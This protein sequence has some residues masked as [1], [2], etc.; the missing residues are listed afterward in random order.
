MM[1]QNQT[2]IVTGAGRGI[3]KAIATALAGEGA[4]IVVADINAEWSEKTAEGLR[5]V[6]RDTLAVSLDVTKSGQIARMVEATLERFKRIDIL[7]N[8]AGV[9]STTPLLQLQE[10]EWDRVLNVNLKGVFLCSKIVAE[11]MIRQR[12]GRII[13]LSSTS[14][15]TGAPGQAAY[16]ASKHGIIGLTEV[17]AIELGPYG[18]TA[19]AVCPG[20]TETEMSLEVFKARAA[21]RGLTVDELLQGIVTKTPL[22]RIGRPEDTADVVVF[23]ASPAAGFVTGQAINV[24]GGR[25]I[26][27]S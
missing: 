18:I 1:L 20:N 16:C 9:M 3:G 21:S 22:G 8:N 15:R 7:V 27:L 17:L 10:E 6:G 23:L 25:S 12:S 19:N 14:G 5:R 26:N 2:A 13:N 11:V 24:C 4:N